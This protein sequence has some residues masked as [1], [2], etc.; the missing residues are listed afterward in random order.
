MAM[1]RIMELERRGMPRADAIQEMRMHMP[2]YTIPY[3]VMGS[4]FLSGAMQD[5]RN[6]LSVFN[7][8]HMGVFKSLAKIV[9]DTASPFASHD[10]RMKAIGNALALATLGYVIKPG[11]DYGWQKLTGNKEAEANPRGPLAPLSHAYKLAR[12]QEPYTGLLGGAFTM[13][14]FLR[15]SFDLLGNKDWRGKTIVE[16]GT[17]FH[18]QLAQF[19][20]HYGYGQIAPLKQF[21]E[22]VNPNSPK[23]SF[24]HELGEQAGDFKNPTQEQIKGKE[25][26]LKNIQQAA[27]GRDKKPQNIVEYGAK[28]LFGYAEGGVV[29][30]QGGSLPPIGQF[31]D[32]LSV[33]ASGPPDA[34]GKPM[35]SDE[36]EA[37]RIATDNALVDAN[38][39]RGLSLSGLQQNFIEPIAQGI[40]KGFYNANKEPDFAKQDMP[41]PSSPN[42]DAA[43]KEMNLSPEEKS[44][45]QRHLTN[46][47][48]DKG[49]DNPDGTRS[50]IYDISVDNN[51]RVYN[52]P[53]IY[54]G[55]KLSP[56]AAMNKADEQGWHTFPNYSSQELADARYNRMHDFMENDIKDYQAKQQQQGATFPQPAPEQQPANL[57]PDAAAPQPDQQVAGIPPP[58]P[59]SNP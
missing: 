58:K 43:H 40:K 46:M 18:H 59:Q 37:R 27:K 15:S 6:I 20:G 50:T 7:R 34:Q 45:Y 35:W 22:S 41:G 17:G 57:A 10:D 39:S 56:D 24:L 21:G 12:G 49:V 44:L 32:V 33:K 23:G 9:N 28:K 2:D 36:D 52:I 48:S 19:L 54:D 3:K 8:Y 25:K 1:Q 5:Q 51:G 47:T 4:S 16:P 29:K 30:D 42:M 26:G 31:N 11:L 14:P 13:S 55:K 38:T 53:T